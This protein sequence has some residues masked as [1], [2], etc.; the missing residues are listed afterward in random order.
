MANFGCTIIYFSY[1]CICNGNRMMFGLVLGVMSIIAVSL[2]HT[3]THAHI[4]IYLR[5]LN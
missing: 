3:Q 4:Y 1:E 2:S 5:S